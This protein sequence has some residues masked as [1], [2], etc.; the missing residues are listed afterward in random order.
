MSRMLRTAYECAKS[1]L[2]LSEHARLVELQ[3]C[4]GL[5]LGSMLFSYH[6]CENI[7]SHIADEM[8]KQLVNYIVKNDCVFSKMIDESTTVS[9]QQG[10]YSHLDR[11]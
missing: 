11:I 10:N 4:N 1:Q 8:R 3:E 6:S 2:S 5:N 9:Q 7:I